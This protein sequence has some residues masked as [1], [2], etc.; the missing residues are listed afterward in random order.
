MFSF[1]AKMCTAV[2][3]AAVIFIAAGAVYAACDSAQFQ[4]ILD[5]VFGDDGH[6]NLPST[7]GYSAFLKSPSCSWAGAVGKANI[8]RFEPAE[9]L[10]VAHQMVLG[11]L[12]K[13]F[14]AYVTLR[15]VDAG[16]LSLDN[17]VHQ[18]FTPQE[19]ADLA[20]ACTTDCPDFSGA[21]ILDLLDA[22]HTFDD[23]VV[24][25]RDRD[26]LGLP[27]TLQMLLRELLKF[28]G[29]ETVPDPAQQT[30]HELLKAVNVRRNLNYQGF[31]TP[32]FGNTGYQLLGIIL[33][34]VTSKSYE[35][36]IAE[37]SLFGT[38]KPQFGFYPNPPLVL[39]AN[40]YT[41]TTGAQQLGLPE[42]LFGIYGAE[43]TPHGHVA[44][45]GR[46]LDNQSAVT[47]S[48]GAGSLLATPSA[49]VKEF[50]RP[51]VN[52]GLL[53]PAGQVV[54]DNVFVP[55]PDEIAQDLFG[56]T[57]ISHG[58]G[59]FQQ[60]GS[61]FGTILF[62]TGGTIA[63]KC[64]LI[65]VRSSPNPDLTNATVFVCMSQRDLF[66]GLLIPGPPTAQQ[67]EDVA[68]RFLRVLGQ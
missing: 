12:T 22:T 43:D 64:H 68:P 66:R 62:K 54:F 8:N 50:F 58:F 31:E 6:G 11:S 60:V 65:H 27:D 49:Y 55:V 17:T 56:A 26:S 41:V 46:N 35:E 48:G 10:T 45:F 5:N 19:L 33:E 44:V 57:G 53:S 28:I 32:N 51:L 34:R 47:G 30:A 7:V 37:N 1:S 59:V 42:N 3:V 63:S 61:E 24:A 9:D 13:M 29:R 15:Q 38:S 67:P 21:T 25:N 14:T 2:V 36:L 16:T 39:A 18:F 4:G 20:G 40:P 23:F 52:G